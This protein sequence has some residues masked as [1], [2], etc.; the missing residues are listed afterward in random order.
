VAGSRDALRFD[1]ADDYVNLPDSDLFDFAQDVDFTISLWVRRD[2][3]SSGSYPGFFHHGAGSDAATG[4]N[5]R[6]TGGGTSLYFQMGNGTSRIG[7]QYPGAFT[8]LDVWHHIVVTADRDGYARLYYDGSQVGVPMNISTHN[9]ALISSNNVIGAWSGTWNGLISDLRI[10]NTALSETQVGL[11]YNGTDITEGLVSHWKLDEEDGTNA[12]DSSGDNDG[13][14]LYGPYWTRQTTDL[15]G[16]GNTGTTHNISYALDHNG[17]YNGAMSFDGTDDYVDCGNNVL[18]DSSEQVTVSFWA[19]LNGYSVQ[20]PVILL[21]KTEQS[22]G[23]GFFYSATSGYTG[24]NFGSNVNFVRLKTAGNIS[25]SFVG[26][27]KNVAMVYDGVSR[28]TNSSYKLYI[29]G[30]EQ[31]LVASSAFT[32][33]PQV[34]NIDTPV[35]NNQFN[36]SID[37][38]RIYDRALDEDEIRTL[39]LGTE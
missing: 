15:S 37:D 35:S 29:N 21:L 28:T 10:Y 26:V 22:T 36:G 3:V 38:L 17:A 25:S 33:V 18:F 9:V 19:K 13:T 24:F 11:L 1:G 27:W 2:G 7:M 20:Y 39:Y 14:L 16:N 31:S 12:E 6:T 4:Y 32:V 5:F 34:N 23:F 8:T 30:V